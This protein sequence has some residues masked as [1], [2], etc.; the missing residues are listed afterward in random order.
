MHFLEARRFEIEHKAFPKR[1]RNETDESEELIVLVGKKLRSTLNGD[2]ESV[3][4]QTAK[5][6]RAA[7]GVYSQ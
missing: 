4:A 5:P 1:P 7:F 3:P 6:K 2:A